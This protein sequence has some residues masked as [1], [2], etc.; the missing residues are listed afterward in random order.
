MC[1]AHRSVKFECGREVVT[2]AVVAIL[3]VVEG[4]NA[5]LSVAVGGGGTS[6]RLEDGNAV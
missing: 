1:V 5:M 3:G 4:G 6:R 2:F